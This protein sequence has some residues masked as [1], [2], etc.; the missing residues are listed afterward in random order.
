MF[1]LI[2]TLGAALCA[3]MFRDAL[4]TRVTGVLAA[5]EEDP[6]PVSAVKLQ[7]FA[8]TIPAEGEIT[9]LQS[10]K[11]RTPQAMPSPAM[12]KPRW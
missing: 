9:G 12:A 2:A 10:E 3:F 8:V 11:V 7:G 4:W 5:S 6:V 1:V